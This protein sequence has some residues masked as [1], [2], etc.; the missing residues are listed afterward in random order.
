MQGRVLLPGTALFEFAAAAAAALA[1][2]GGIPPG[3]KPLLSALSIISPKVLGG[4][5]AGGEAAQDTNGGKAAAKT[6]H[7]DVILCEVQP[8]VGQ[9]RVLSAPQAANGAAAVAPAHVK[10]SISLAAD[11][12]ASVPVA[13]SA[14][15]GSATAA[16]A[17]VLRGIAS[18][19]LAGQASCGGGGGCRIAQPRLQLAAADMSAGSFLMHPAV[20]DNVLHLG[21]VHVAAGS[22]SASRVPVGVAAYRCSPPASADRR[23]NPDTMSPGRT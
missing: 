12:T 17:Q 19:L 7:V 3:L 9:L 14:A 11:E 13:A 20:A 21:A 4:L 23:V 16:A 2:D 10:A 1:G 5:A 15:A 8:A 6:E 18:R 22:S